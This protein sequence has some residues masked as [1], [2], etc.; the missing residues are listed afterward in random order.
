[1]RVHSRLHPN[2]CRKQIALAPTPKRCSCREQRGLEKQWNLGGSFRKSRK[3][4]VR[5]IPFDALSA[6]SAA[7]ATFETAFKSSVAAAMGGTVDTNDVTINSITAGVSTSRLPCTY[8]QS[9][10]FA[11][12]CI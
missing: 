10:L 5:A 6:T 1:M 9:R 8:I 12:H 4:S 3:Q 7:R 11:L 2:R